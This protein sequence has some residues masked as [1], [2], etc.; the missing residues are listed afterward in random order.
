[1]EVA[2]QP[3]KCPAAFFPTRLFQSLFLW[4]WLYSRAG[5]SETGSED[6]VSILVFMEVALQHRPRGWRYLKRRSFNPCF[7]G[8]GSTAITADLIRCL[9]E[10][11]QSLFLWKWLYSLHRRGHNRRDGVV[12]ILVFMEVA[13]QQLCHCLSPCL[14]FV[15]ILVF[16]EVALQHRHAYEEEPGVLVSILVFMEVALQLAGGRH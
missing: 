16:M 4:K 5:R 3:N 12:S 9:S 7:Y 6:V 1:M 2:L 10:G 14:L 13:L 11:F 8:S 15:S